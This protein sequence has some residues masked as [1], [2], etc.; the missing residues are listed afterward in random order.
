MWWTWRTSP[1]ASLTFRPP[2]T[3]SRSKYR[4]LLLLS[5]FLHF[6]KF[7]WKIQ[8]FQDVTSCR[9]DAV[10][11]VVPS[12]GQCTSTYSGSPPHC[13]YLQPYLP[14]LA[15]RLLVQGFLYKVTILKFPT[16]LV[17]TICSHLHLE[18]LK[19]LQM[20][21]IDSSHHMGWL[22]SRWTSSTSPLA[23]MWQTCQTF[24]AK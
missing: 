16:H 20:N 18:K 12:L 7:V 22:G 17:K 13:P 9:G 1:L 19:N 2:S 23:C 21:H 10:H 11:G 3:S 14:Y 24:L 4:C 6:P 5:S 15:A 8:V